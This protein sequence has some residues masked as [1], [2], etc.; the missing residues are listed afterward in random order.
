VH[1]ACPILIEARRHSLDEPRADAPV[2]K[3]E[4]DRQRSE[5]ADAA[6]AGCEVGAHQFTA[7]LRSKGRDVGRLPAATYV[8]A[9]GPEHL[10]FG[11]AQEGAKGQPENPL[12]FR[13]IGLG[14]RAGG[15]AR[16]C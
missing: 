9:V 8:V 10:W 1:A 2:P 13:Q 15:Y 16:C 7:N 14:Q 11:S 6:P 12:G 4:A 3:V 5:E